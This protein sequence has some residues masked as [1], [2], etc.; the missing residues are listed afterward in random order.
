MYTVTN[1][2]H[3][4]MFKFRSQTDGQSFCEGVNCAM[5]EYQTHKMMPSMNSRHNVH[6]NG[7]DPFPGVEHDVR[8]LMN[9]SGLDNNLLKD[10]VSRKE[11]E[12]FC[13][14]NN[15]SQEFERFASRGESRIVSYRNSVHLLEVE[16]LRGKKTISIKGIRDLINT[17]PTST[18]NFPIPIQVP[19]T[20]PEYPEEDEGI[21]QNSS[22]PDGDCQM[23]CSVPS[24][25][26]PKYTFAESIKLS[27]KKL[28]P[29]EASDGSERSFEDIRT[30]LGKGLDL[31]R[32][33]NDSGSS[34]ESDEDNSFEEK[35]LLE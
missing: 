24:S 5:H 30:F 27:L 35:D 19:A 21:L 16:N 12:D 28:K 22:H 23:A 11:I 7:N 3:I 32:I 29:V 6:T 13:K 14:N 25:D 34:S 15:V 10:P 20:L 33:A 1:D 31:I 8:Q 2:E 18:E 17:M 4:M 9:F 26:S